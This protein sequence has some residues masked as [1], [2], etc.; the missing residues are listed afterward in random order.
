MTLTIYVKVKVIQM[1]LTIYVKVK[2]IKEGGENPL[3]GIFSGFLN[4]II[5]QIYDILI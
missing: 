5:L 1:T 3:F 4:I 2:V